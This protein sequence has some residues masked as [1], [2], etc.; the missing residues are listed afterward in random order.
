MKPVLVLRQVAHETTG[1]LQ[2][3]LD[4]AGLES[5]YVDLFAEVTARL[6]LAQAAGL[7]VLGGP[8][9]VDQTDRYPFLGPEVQWIRRA[10]ESGLPVLGICLGSQLLAKALGARVFPNDTKEIGWYPIELT[11]AAA[12]DRLFRTCWEAEGTKP[13]VP[14]RVTVFQWHGDTFDLPAGAVRL[15][16]GASCAQQAFRYGD[17]AYALQ[18]H[19]EMTPE[20]LDDWLGEPGNCG[21]LAE[22]DYIDPQEIRRRTPQELHALQTLARRMFG[23]FADMCQGRA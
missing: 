1:T 6:D 9:N 20:M 5:R 4:E 17:F 3:A 18:F 14:K 10:V 16:H 19:L 7:V 8:M 22:L 15:A 11:P 2:A 23:Q 13:M 12:E 21:E